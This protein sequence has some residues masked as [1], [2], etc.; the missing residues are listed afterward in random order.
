MR[1]PLTFDSEKKAAGEF[2][3][4]GNRET[5]M[6]PEPNKKKVLTYMRRP[7]VLRSVLN[8]ATRKTR[9]RIN[10]DVRSSE[11]ELIVGIL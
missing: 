3:I 7:G 4:F 5:R 6:S 9:P 1:P 8:K 10:P 11:N 2:I